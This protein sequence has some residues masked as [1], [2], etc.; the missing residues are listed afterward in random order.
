MQQAHG[1]D[2]SGMPAPPRSPVRGRR[3]VATSQPLAAQAGLRAMQR[4]GNAIDAA[5]AAAITLTVVEPTSNGIGGDAFAIVWDGEKLHGLN[6]SGRS[7]AEWDASWRAETLEGRST[8]PRFGWDAVTVPGAVSAWVALSERLGRFPFAALFEDAIRHA[9]DGFAVGPVTAKAWTRAPRYADRVGSKIFAAF[10]DTFL[11][12]GAS[13]QDG[14]VIRLPDH[15][16]TL[17]QIAATGG[18]AFYQGVLAEKIIAASDAAGGRMSLSDLS[19]HA[20]DWVA[21][22]GVSYR[23]KTIWELPPNGQGMAALIA[24]GILDQLEAPDLHQTIEAMKTGLSETFEHNADPDHATLVLATFL[25]EARLR[26]HVRALPDRAT[27]V[28][29]PPQADHGTVYLSAADDEGRMVS[30]IQSNYMGFGSGVVVPGTG[31]AMQNRGA[32]FNLVEGHPNCV[33]PRKRPYHTIIPALATC[34]GK[35]HIAFGVM[36]GHHQPQGHVQVIRNLLDEGLDP[37]AALDR[38]RWHLEEDG[39][40]L[41]EQ[42]FPASQTATLAERGHQIEIAE[43]SGAFGGG[44]IVMVDENDATGNGWIGGTDPRKEGCVAAD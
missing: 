35:P 31:I 16:D 39:R 10:A 44:Q 19:R 1:I 40:F 23:G 21:P 5:I 28:P 33:G 17:E 24:L 18:A 9:R 25:N 2:A 7:P 20:P 22:L 12:G 26:Q 32:G 11:P 43:S 41:V 36:G 8:M 14:Q 37:Q 30:F 29:R 13:P 38:R 34:D 3:M 42:G 27:P 6:A 15:A 4:G